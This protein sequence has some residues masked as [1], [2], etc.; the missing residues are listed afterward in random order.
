VAWHIAVISFLDACIVVY[1]IE[2][3]DPFHARLMKRLGA[4]RTRYPEASFAVSRLSWMECMVKPL[5]DN[6]QALIDEY[7]AFFDAGQ[8]RLVEL[9]ASVVEQ[10][11]LLRAKHALKTPDALQAACALELAGERLFLTN[12]TSFK[13]VPGL[14]VEIPQR[15]ER[16]S[17]RHGNARAG[18][19]ARR[20][21]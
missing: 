20:L 17:G 11:T 4:L 2:A 19:V 8:L 21:G 13:K 15:R 5:R 10:A 14:Q 9:T 16:A 3:P 1:W 6:D 7:R 18:T 12:D